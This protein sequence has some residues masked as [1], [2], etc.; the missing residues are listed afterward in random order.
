MSVK[1]VEGDG[2]K[3][4]ATAE[5]VADAVGPSDSGVEVLTGVKAVEL[6]RA[7]E[8]DA[9]AG[10]PAPAFDG[11]E[12]QTGVVA[13]EQQKRAA[14]AQR[15]EHVPEKF[16]D[17]E[18]GEIRVDGMAKSYAELERR[19]GLKAEELQGVIEDDAVQEKLAEKLKAAGIEGD[20]DLETAAALTAKM[21]ARPESAAAYEIELPKDTLPEGL[22]FQADEDNPLMQHWRETAFANGLSKDEFNAGV[23]AYAKALVA[24]M[25]DPDTELKALGTRGVE[26]VNAVRQFVDKHVQDPALRDA[27]A[28]FA[29]TAA[30][31]QVFEA[32]A[33]ANVPTKID[34]GDNDARNA[35]KPPTPGELS[36]MVADPRY[37]SDTEYHNRVSALYAKAYPGQTQ[38]AA[39]NRNQRTG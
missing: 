21:K 23:A 15:P 5:A 27:A 12:V 7:S 2:A 13:A 8:A 30:G 11:A 6:A 39:L 18:K 1:K 19:M 38:T 36:A 28:A 16:W 17:A 32:L 34:S 37:W 4:E 9:D 35:D 22:E 14:A 3:A 31:V 29:D 10:D 24:E 33:A 20:V 26:R 25:P